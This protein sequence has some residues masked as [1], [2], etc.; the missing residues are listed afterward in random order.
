MKKIKIL[1]FILILTSSIKSF[2]QTYNMPAESLQHEGTWLQWPH[3]YEYGLTYRNRLDATWVAM[4]AALVQS[5]KVHIIAYN[6]TEQTRIT[7]LLIAANVSLTNVNF[8]IFPTND[9]WVRDN[10]PVYVNDA[11]NNLTIEDWGFNGWG[12]YNYNNDNPIPTSV[13]TANGTPIVNLNS[14]MT[15]EGGAYEIDGN[16]VFLA[17]KS[18]ILSQSPANSVRNSG[19]TQTQAQTILT[20]YLGVTKFIWLNGNVGDPTDVTDF[21]IDG[22]AKFLNKDTLITMNNADL[23]YWGASAADISTLYN[24]SNIN[25][26]VY[27][28]IYLPLTHNNVTTAYGNPLYYKGS[29][30]N[31]YVA[32]SV[33]L[34]PNYNDPHDAVANAIIQSLYPNRTVIGIDCRNLYENGGMVH[35]VTQQ[36][37]VASTT[38][39]TPTNVTVPTIGS[40]TATI[41]WTGNSGAIKYELQYRIQGTSTW[42]TK[43]ITAP[44]VTKNLTSLVASSVY[45]YHIKT[46]YNTAGTIYSPYTTT[47]T[48]TT[49]CSCGKPTNIIVSPIT[50]TAATFNWTGNSCAVKYRLQTRKQGTTTWTTSYINAPATTFALSNLIANT[51]YEYRMRTDCNSAGTV[52]S[53]YTTTTTFTSAMRLGNENGMKNEIDF[54]VFPN[55]SNGNFSIQLNGMEKGNGKISVVNLLGQEV[56]QENISIA[57]GEN[58]FEISLGEMTAGI[59]FVKVQ[60]NNF[61]SSKMIDV[62]K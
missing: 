61:V 6:S 47:Q 33:V 31:Y 26:V 59:Y 38:Y 24:A 49:L 3:Q 2:S 27:T 36:Q 54:S 48:F 7:N 50:Q 55:P 25:N 62:V 14:I 45:E 41:S 60:I 18:S 16:G 20:Q 22:F 57:E 32:N 4:T 1:F 10:G 9:V 58:N 13:A 37:P 43:T 15:I 39:A 5:E 51:T 56:M 53:S 19:M 12:D 44:T 11:T 46:D 29:Y 35:C 17:C 8:K 42:T 21:H 34:V 40:T 30:A 52:Y 28:K 23:I